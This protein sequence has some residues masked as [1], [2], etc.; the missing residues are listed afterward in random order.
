MAVGIIRVEERHRKEYVYPIAPTIV[1]PMRAP[2]N[3]D[4]DNNKI[5][6]DLFS[7]R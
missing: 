2:N 3:D 6:L 7:C 1:G 4:K 5:Y